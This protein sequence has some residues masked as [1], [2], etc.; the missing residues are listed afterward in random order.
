MTD[1]D[2]PRIRTSAAT[3][4]GPNG[5][6]EP[7][8]DRFHGRP[9]EIERRVA[10]ERGA[11]I[12]RGVAIELDAVSHQWQDTRALA[13]TTATIA[14]GAFVAIVGPSGC[15]KS[16]LLRLLAGLDYPTG[17]SIRVDNRDPDALRADHGIG[18]LAQRPALLPWLTAR[19]NVALAD[20]IHGRDADDHAH[21][22]ADELLAMVGLDGFGDHLPS[23]LSGGM[24]QRIGLARTLALR[25]PLWLMDEP[26]AALDELTRSRV[27]DDL[28]GIWQRLRPTVAWVTHH[29]GE[30]VSLADRVLVLSARPGH[31]VADIPVSTPRPRDITLPVHQDLVRAARDVLDDDA[32]GVAA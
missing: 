16:T 17:G 29:L 15:G 27:A 24:R 14:P 9:A 5:L 8:H 30:A 28:V 18:W 2:D 4:D 22:H 19:D 12:E 20:R 31:I 26:L 21:D 11:A 23:Q 7:A 25:A 32:T 3:T 6:A 10:D 13:P 1:P